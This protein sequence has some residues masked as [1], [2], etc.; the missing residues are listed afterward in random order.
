[1]LLQ[2][3]D[4]ALRRGQ[5]CHVQS[6]KSWLLFAKPVRTFL[7]QYILGAGIWAASK[8]QRQNSPRCRLVEACHGLPRELCHLSNFLYLPNA[9]AI[10]AS[11]IGL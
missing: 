9:A 3:L 8:L 2:R 11:K 5:A 4:D 7:V 6:V 10:S 1:M